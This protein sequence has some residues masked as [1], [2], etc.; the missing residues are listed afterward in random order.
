M[1]PLAHRK[2]RGAAANMSEPRP[3]ALQLAELGLPEHVGRGRALAMRTTVPACLFDLVLSMRCHA[4]PRAHYGGR[5]R[6]RRRARRCA[7]RRAHRHR[8]HCPSH[9]TRRACCDRPGQPVCHIRLLSADARS[10]SL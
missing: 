7:R 10:L 2:F 6:A 9:R 1:P 4:H 3:L 5:C 8:A